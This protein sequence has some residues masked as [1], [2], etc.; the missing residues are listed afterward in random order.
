M[1]L[2][3]RGTVR[4]KAHAIAAGLADCEQALRLSTDLDLSV[5]GALCAASIALARAWRG[6]EALA[7]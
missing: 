7:A 2:A 4:M 6:E 3:G 5:V 1:A